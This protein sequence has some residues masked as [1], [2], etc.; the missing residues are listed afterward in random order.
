MYKIIQGQIVH[1]MCYAP[2]AWVYSAKHEVAQF[3]MSQM[4]PQGAVFSYLLFEQW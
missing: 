4:H 2:R 3:G 1:C